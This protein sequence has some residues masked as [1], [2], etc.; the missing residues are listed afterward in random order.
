[1][2]AGSGTRLHGASSV[3]GTRDQAESFRS[4]GLPWQ[5][6]MQTFSNWMGPFNPHFYWLIIQALLFSVSFYRLT[7]PSSIIS[8]SLQIFGDWRHKAHPVNELEIILGFIQRMREPTY[9]KSPEINLTE[10]KAGL[11]SLVLW[12]PF[13]NFFTSSFSGRKHWASGLWVSRTVLCEPGC[14]GQDNLILQTVP[15]SGFFMHMLPGRYQKFLVGENEPEE[16][17]FSAPDV[18]WGWTQLNAAVLLLV[19]FSLLKRSHLNS[20]SLILHVLSLCWPLLPR[21]SGKQR[22]QA[23]EW[24]DE[25]L[26]CKGRRHR[27]EKQKWG[28]WTAFPRH[29]FV[30]V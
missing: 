5:L 18:S 9:C 2:W 16:L 15:G 26:C 25:V 23:N 8:K 1:M 6:G 17:S 13:V 4:E 28:G 7:F 30:V 10:R 12:T 11:N 22:T 29:N 27:A 3:L 19:A 20:A 21:S 14:R 24:G